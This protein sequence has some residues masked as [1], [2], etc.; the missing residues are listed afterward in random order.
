MKLGELE[1]S[2]SGRCFRGWVLV[3][4]LPL[5]VLL[6]K[7][8]HEPLWLFMW[9]LAFSIFAGLKWL[10]WRRTKTKPVPWWRHAAYLFLWPGLDARTF[11]E[12]R[13]NLPAPTPREWGASVV[14]LLT[15]LLLFFVV[16]GYF[17]KLGGYF[18]G[19]MGMIGIVLI[20]HFGSFLI[21]SCFWRSRGVGAAPLMN[22]PIRSR[23]LSEFW[24]KR[25][26]TAFR[27]L[28]HRF[29]F[30][31]LT[32]RLGPRIGI[33]SGFLLS[34]LIHDVVIS[35]PANGGYGLPTLYFVLQSAGFFLERSAWGK[36]L[37]LKR[38][39]RGWLY[40]MG[41]LAIPLPLLF[42]WPF[43]QNVVLPF[44]DAAGAI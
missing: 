22:Q 35:I 38:M 1:S 29:L 34:G 16:P 19:W 2:E 14:C 39:P 26:N 3:I 41:F 43:I 42:H 5:G 44:M 24:G 33:F 12:D 8:L 40:T 31:P 32:A 15:G 25:W 17:P 27:D 20:L 23:S 21:L 10:T 18:I 7:P 6:A 30:L 13:S 9:L 28:T 36:A 37:G 4:L 11:L